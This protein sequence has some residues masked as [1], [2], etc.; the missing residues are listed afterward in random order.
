MAGTIA[1]VCPECGKQVQAPPELIGKKVRCKG[2][3]T[4]FTVQSAAQKTAIK[5]APSKPAG[6]VKAAA[7]APKGKPPAAKPVAKPQPSKTD[8]DDEDDGN[9]YAVTTLDLSPRCPECANEL[10]SADAI[11]CLTCGYNTETRERARTR[12]V[13]ETTGLDQTLWL[14]PGIACVIA[15]ILLIVF[16]VIYCIKASEWFKDTW[17]EGFGDHLGIKMWLV[18]CCIFA[19]WYAGK[20]AVKRLILHPTPP[21][22]ELYE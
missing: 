18:I 20:F 10:E 4:V 5:T 19:S 22:V 17:A 2:C 1:V 7:P 14:L 16:D 15:I 13:K 21:E 12:K 9:P 8:D 3:S 11:I 6:P